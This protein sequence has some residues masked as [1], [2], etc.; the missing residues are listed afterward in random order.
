MI[1]MSFQDLKFLL[2]NALLYRFF[3]NLSSRVFCTPSEVKF[4]VFG[5][6]KHGEGKSLS[7]VFLLFLSV[8]CGDFIG[9]IK[10]NLSYTLK[11]LI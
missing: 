8:H 6:S 3:A 10:K 9:Q 5:T 7:N 4:H 2:N 1:V 11:A